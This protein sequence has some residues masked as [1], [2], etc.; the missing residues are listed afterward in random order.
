MFKKIFILC[1]TLM[2]MLC[3]F[4]LAIA[5]EQEVA[6]E[7]YNSPRW[8]LIHRISNV[9]SINRAGQANMTSYISI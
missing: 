1:L 6:H 7:F 4:S 8:T 3:M 5:A 9:L 2:F